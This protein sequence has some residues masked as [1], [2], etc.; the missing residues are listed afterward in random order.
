MDIKKVHEEKLNQRAI[1][2]WFTGL[3]GSGK[4]TLAVALQQKLL[5]ENKITQ[6]LD[7]DLLRNSLNKNLGFSEE[8][9]TENIRRVAEVSK[10]FLDCGIICINA[11]ISPTHQIRDLAKSIIGEKR[12]VEIYLNTS[13][14]AC[15]KRDP[16]G[17]YLKARNGELKNFT[18]I[19]SIFEQPQNPSLIID[20]E[21][22]SINQS[23]AMIYNYILTKIH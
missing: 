19:D 12:F 20:T 10:L 7:G 1:C 16:K 15:E 13:I 18:G 14:E 22:L 9:R 23:V 3:S 6:Y 21:I 5:L 8:D 17:L 4:S 11:F 2:I